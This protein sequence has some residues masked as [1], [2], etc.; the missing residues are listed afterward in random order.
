[1]EDALARCAKNGRIDMERS[2]P[3]RSYPMLCNAKTSLG[4]RRAQ[5][6]IVLAKK[7]RLQRR[8]CNK[9]NDFALPN[10]NHVVLLSKSSFHSR[11]GPFPIFR[12]PIHLTA[13]AY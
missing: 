9:S 5:G 1:M 3:F 11:V 2:K 8:I 4:Q 10:A 12:L 13:E 7:F 6:I